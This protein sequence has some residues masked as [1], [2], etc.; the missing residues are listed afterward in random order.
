M[1]DDLLWLHNKMMC[2]VNVFPEFEQAE[3]F[4]LYKMKVEFVKFEH[5]VTL[6]CLQQFVEIM[7]ISSLASVATVKT[8][9]FWSIYN[10]ISIEIWNLNMI[11]RR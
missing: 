1:N 11:N 6:F 7:P 3:I 10:A 8:K 5:D 4:I 2:K 9:C